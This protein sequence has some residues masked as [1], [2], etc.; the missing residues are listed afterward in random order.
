MIDMQMESGV[1][2]GYLVVPE[3]GAGTLPGVILYM[4][5]F[6]PRPS[7]FAMADRLAGEGYAVLVPDLFYRFGTYG[8]FDAKTAFKNEETGKELRGMLG[9]TTQAMTADDT[10][11]F[12]ETLEK[13][14]VDGPIGVVGYCMGGARAMTAAAVYGDRIAAA[15]SLHGGNLASEAADSPHLKAAD[16][17]GL[18][19][20]GNADNDGSLPREQST[21]LADAMRAAGVD[22]TFENYLGV[23]HGWCIPDH[24]VYDERGAERHW[25]RITTL[26]AETLKA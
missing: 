21:R 18:V 22:F 2:K 14:G 7:L 20:V 13:A 10:A 23:S 11:V 24:G 8:P 6:G 12:I 25:R 19:Y 4:D 15:A 3:R 26:F 5:I 16:I 9:A 1:A 17:R